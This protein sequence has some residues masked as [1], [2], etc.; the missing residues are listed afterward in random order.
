MAFSSK[1]EQKSDAAVITLAG[2]LDTPAAQVFKE[3]V[4]RATVSHPK[5]L[6][7]MMGDLDYIA[8]AGLRVLIFARQKM[9]S[10]V[11]IYIIGAQD[12]VVDTLE[13]TG[14][15]N[16]VIMQDTYA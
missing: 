10:G 3:D 4:E 14:F 12:Q 2:E 13:K 1:L 5:R 11:D 6:V 7:L 8:S 9:G 15:S 16:S